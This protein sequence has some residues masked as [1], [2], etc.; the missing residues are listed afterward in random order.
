MHL[1]AVVRD[2]ERDLARGDRLLREVVAVLEHPDLTVVFALPTG[3]VGGG[4][5]VVVVVVVFCVVV[6]TGL[7][8]TANFPF[9]PAFACPKIVQ[10]N[11]YWPFFANFTVSFAALPGSSVFVF[12]PPILKSCEILPLLMT[13]KITVPVR[14]AL[15]REDVLELG[16]LHG[17]L[18]GRVGRVRARRTG[19][20]KDAGEHAGEASVAN[21]ATP[22]TP[23]YFIRF[24]IY[25]L[26]P[27]RRQSSSKNL[28]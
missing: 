20:Q 11:A 16:R 26:P 27:V 21:P 23:L 5:V 17:H 24:L 9:M 12:L 22:T 2:H 1:A 8:A 15:L 18:V 13:V 4:V 6:A 25:V 14:D 3:P 7:T 28:N 10:R 19:G